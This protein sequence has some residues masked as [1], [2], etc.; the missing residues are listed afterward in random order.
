MGRTWFPSISHM[1]PT[2][3]PMGSRSNFLHGSY[4]VPTR[5]QK[6]PQGSYMGPTWFPHASHVG[7]MWAFPV[8]WT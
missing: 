2:W 6:D 3:F 1:G 8:G 4:M 7:P 5:T